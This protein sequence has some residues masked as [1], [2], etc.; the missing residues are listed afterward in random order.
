MA[1][2]EVSPSITKEVLRLQ[3][4]GFRNEGIAVGPIVAVAGEQTHAF[5]LALDDQ[6]IPVMFYFVQPVRAGR[7]LGA[8]RRDAGFERS[9]THSV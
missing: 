2:Q 4:R 8:A 7:N 5:A 1:G 6:A 9:L 3:Q